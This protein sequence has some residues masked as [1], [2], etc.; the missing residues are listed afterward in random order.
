MD[1]R[2]RKDDF[3]FAFLACEGPTAT[4]F[5]FRAFGVHKTARATR[6]VIAGRW[7]GC[8]SS[9]L[10]GIRKSPQNRIV[11]RRTEIFDNA[12]KYWI[13]QSAG[14]PHVKVERDELMIQMQLRLVV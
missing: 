10:I 2:S 4:S 11:P 13:E 12:T 14:V 9:E 3:A 7:W 5:E 8:G 1:C 6:L